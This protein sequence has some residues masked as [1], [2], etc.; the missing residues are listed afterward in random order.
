[1]S[2]PDGHQTCLILGNQVPWAIK[3]TT[4]FL[5]KMY[6]HIVIFGIYFETYNDLDKK[7]S[8][9]VLTVNG[10]PSL[11]WDTNPH[12]TSKQTVEFRWELRTH[13]LLPVGEIC[14]YI[15][16]KKMQSMYT[17]QTFK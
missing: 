4:D 14:W 9:L 5:Y 16:L 7:I 6:F 10:E 11:L 2:V 15:Y 1:M 17:V 3:E 8:T 13:C 12:Q